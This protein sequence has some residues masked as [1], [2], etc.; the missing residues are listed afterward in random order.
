MT[1]EWRFLTFEI[2]FMP[3]ISLKLSCSNEL[4]LWEGFKN[5]TKKKKNCGLKCGHVSSSLSADSSTRTEEPL[6]GL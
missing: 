4:D 5:K 6:S 2:A 3:V 1:T